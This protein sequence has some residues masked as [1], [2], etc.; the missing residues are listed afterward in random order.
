M[1]PPGRPR[2]SAT[3]APP[4]TRLRRAE[5]GRTS[6]RAQSCQCTAALLQMLVHVTVRAALV[7][8]YMPS[9]LPRQA[10]TLHERAPAQEEHPSHTGVSQ[11]HRAKHSRCS[12]E[13]SAAHNCRRQYPPR[14]SSPLQYHEQQGQMGK[15]QD[16]RR[17]HSRACRVCFE[18][19]RGTARR[20]SS[21]AVAT[22]RHSAFCAS[23]QRL[24][25][26]RRFITP[27]SSSVSY[28]A[29]VHDVSLARTTNR[30]RPGLPVWSHVL[31]DARDRQL[32]VS[33]AR[34][35]QRC[36]PDPRISGGRGAT[37]WATH[38]LAQ[39]PRPGRGL[40]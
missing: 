4:G 24:S 27:R 19:C 22:R 31:R 12:L 10:M 14:R 32:L 2:L 29:P 34:E 39:L 36:E 6:G 21:T 26:P 13:P 3:R 18:G 9:P 25:L 7:I 40:A 20:A 8:A 15:H 1:G 37:S 33:F 23:A 17:L 38:G 28:S 11:L 30:T 16:P 5:R 35:V